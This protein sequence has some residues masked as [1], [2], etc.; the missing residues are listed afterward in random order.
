MV[1]VCEGAPVAVV[2]AIARR[3]EARQDLDSKIARWQEVS[4]PVLQNVQNTATLPR[5]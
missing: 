3:R 2:M 4:S 5:F 1:Q